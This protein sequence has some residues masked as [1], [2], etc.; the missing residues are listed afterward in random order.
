MAIDLSAIAKWPNVPACYDW[1]SLD[2]RGDWRLQGERVTHSGL[3]QFIN[4]QYGRDESGCWFLQNGPQRVF[5]ALAS[6][7]WIFRREGTGFVSHTGAPT[8]LLK[9]LYLDEDGNLLLEAEL[10][11]GLL[12]DRDL[13][14]ILAECRAGNGKLAS[15]EAIIHLMETGSGD[16]HWQ[17]LRVQTIAAADLP[18]RFSFNP[19]PRP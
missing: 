9:A 15:D 13:A 16:I 19:N 11:I 18:K 12:D 5:V 2:R 6:T 8:G 3:I 10:G 14:G 17:N 7:P 1:L 4:R